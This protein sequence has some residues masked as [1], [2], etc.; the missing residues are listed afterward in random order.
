MFSFSDDARRPDGGPVP[1]PL[2]QVVQAYSPRFA[3]FAFEPGF[4][5]AVDQHA[6]ELR[7]R[8]PSQR[9][10]V[11]AVGAAGALF[12]AGRPDREAL[13]DYALGFTDALAEI[14]WRE[15]VGHDYAVVR[16]T[17]LCLLVNSYGLLH[18]GA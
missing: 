12:G 1:C 15:P 7:D 10:P 11:D 9:T 16:L 8:F 14:G 18:P 3:E 17:A 2:R 5:A 13:S 6:A 4:V